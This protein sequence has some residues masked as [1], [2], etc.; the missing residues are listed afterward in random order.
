MANGLFPE[1]TVNRR[2][3]DRLIDLADRR[4]RFGAMPATGH[5]T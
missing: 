2:V 1:G 5:D 4:R 3:E